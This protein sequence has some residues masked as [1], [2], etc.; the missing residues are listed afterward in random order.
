MLLLSGWSGAAGCTWR[1]NAHRGRTVGEVLPELTSH[2]CTVILMLNAS[3][4]HIQV[5]RETL[6]STQGC[7]LQH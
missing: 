6:A 4:S 1:V 5:L 3:L 2:S 7:R